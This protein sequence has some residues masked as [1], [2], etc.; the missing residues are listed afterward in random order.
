VEGLLEFLWI[1]V[2]GLWFVV[3]LWAM[4]DAGRY[5][6]EVWRDTGESKTLWFLLI[7]VVPFL[8]TLLYL[9]TVRPKL[10]YNAP[11]RRH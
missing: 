7:L 10:R 3:W 5:P 2:G 6:D 1:P 4:F 11:A 8:G 9:V